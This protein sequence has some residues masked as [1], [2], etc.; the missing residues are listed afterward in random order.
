MDSLASLGDVMGFVGFGAALLVAISIP[1]AEDGTFTNMTKWLM[2]AS[3]GVYFFVTG[4]EVFH[5][6]FS[7]TLLQDLDDYVEVLFPVLVM[8]SVFAAYVAQQMSD[9]RRAQSAMTRSYRMMV[10]IVDAAP[11]GI[12][13]LDVAGRVN[14]AND[15]ARE[16][17][18]LSEDYRRGGLHTPEWTVTCAGSEP[19]ADFGG[20]VG[21]EAAE[22][23]D[24]A[25]EWPNG[26][27][28]DLTVSTHLLSERSGR[29]GGVVATFERPTR[30]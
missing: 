10:D 24:V 15:T 6:V 22:G 9:L 14:F 30:A 18:D 20:L 17:L 7:G 8:L 13:V 25:V 26:W 16:V 11:A 2:A 28:V 19:A 29:L 12:L 5:S 1:T 27:R 3:F 23:V 4:S 21:E